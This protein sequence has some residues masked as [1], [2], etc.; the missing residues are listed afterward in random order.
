[1]EQLHAV[2]S[3]NNNSILCRWRFILLPNV[4]GQ[5]RA[6]KRASRFLE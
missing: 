2:I 3:A 5:P 1:L 6:D 4:R